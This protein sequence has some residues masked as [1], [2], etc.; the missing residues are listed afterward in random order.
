M[1]DNTLTPSAPQEGAGELAGLLL[2]DIGTAELE[3]LAAFMVA[4]VQEALGKGWHPAIAQC[5]AEFTKALCTAGQA[6]QEGKGR[7]NVVYGLDLTPAPH[8]QL[9]AAAKLLSDLA[10]EAPRV[11]LTRRLGLN[12]DD[13]AGLLRMARAPF[14]AELTARRLARARGCN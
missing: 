6:R 9:A 4:V 2:H 11:D 7:P 3:F 14:D 1:G 8:D 5:L 10:A 12:R 13:L